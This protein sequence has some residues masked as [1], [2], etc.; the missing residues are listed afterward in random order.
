MSTPRTKSSPQNTPFSPLSP[1][2]YWNSFGVLLM[3]TC[4]LIFVSYAFRRS[5]L[6]NLRFF[7]GIA[8]LQFFPKFQTISAGLVILPLLIVLSITALKDGYE[9]I[10]R[11]QSD[12]HVN[13]TQVRILSGGDWVNHNPMVTKSKTFVRGITSRLRVK[14]KPSATSGNETELIERERGASLGSLPAT[15]ATH[16][17]DVEHN[18][19]QADREDPHPH[20]DRSG[21]HWKQTLWEDVRVG[22]FIKIVDNQS[23][24]ADILIC[25]TSEEENEA[26]VETKNLD[27]ET[28]LKSRHAVP[29]LTHL[30]TAA[31]CAN[32]S[33][34][35]HIECNRPDVDMYKLNAAVAVGR[36]R[37][38]VNVQMTLL[39]GTVLRNTKWVIGVVL[40]T[41][42]D[43]KIVLNSGG[44]PSKQSKVE[45][46]MNPQVYVS[47]LL[48]YSTIMNLF[49]SFL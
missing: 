28:N 8:V 35:F 22:D 41:G 25:S 39:R 17:T 1:E 43:T 10:K 3:C 15:P 14:K 42:G 48:P 30:R 20:G 44:T 7:F 23:F 4:I 31:D 29:E 13:H 49:F 11:H 9:D 27:G 12:R 33:N 2:I 6:A 47:C 26:F 46:Q 18:A 19:D 40:F 32:K 45:R 5:L 37:Y 36:D 34:A 38:P 16:R 21:P 24:P